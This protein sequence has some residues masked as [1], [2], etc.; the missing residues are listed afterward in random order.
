MVFGYFSLN[1]FQP[2]VSHCNR[3]LTF[4]FS[5]CFSDLAHGTK[6]QSF[7]PLHCS[8]PNQTRAR[9]QQTSPLI[10]PLLFCSSIVL[11]SIASLNVN[12]KSSIW[13]WHQQ[14]ALMKIGST[15]FSLLW[16]NCSLSFNSSKLNPHG[17][18][19]MTKLCTICIRRIHMNNNLT[20][21]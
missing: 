12:R 4:S 5:L 14:T 8:S 16:P 10:L 1:I 17:E 3:L 7:Q 21:N 6:I 2:L 15:K 20:E 19:Y 13:I 9:V 11:K 18:S